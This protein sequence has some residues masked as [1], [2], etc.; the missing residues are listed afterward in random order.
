VNDSEALHILGQAV[1]TASE[2]LI[3]V[4]TVALVVGVA[5]S[6]LQAVTQVQEMTLTFVP[7][8]AGITAVLLVMGHWMMNQLVDFTRELLLDIPRLVTG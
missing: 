3:P 7:K 1:M 4:L 8:L 6:I 2:L 5:I